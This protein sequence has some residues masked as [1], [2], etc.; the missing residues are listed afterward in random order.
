METRCTCGAQCATFG[1]CLRRKGIRIGYCQSAKGHDYSR[2]RA[3]DRELDLY[4][5]ARR[6]GI[7]PGGT[8]TVASEF[9]IAMSEKSG[10]AF[11]AETF[12]RVA[13]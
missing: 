6:Q 13:E 9:A 1:E 11:N 4:R 10:E 12:G 2:Q 5:D 8:S 7:Q 3:W